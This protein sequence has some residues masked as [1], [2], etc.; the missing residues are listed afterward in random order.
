MDRRHWIAFVAIAALA[1]TET[2]AELFRCT[3][4]DG[5]T[6][7]TDQKGACPDAEP[8]E[9]SGVVHSAPPSPTRPPA[10][11]Q[12]DRHL[13]ERAEEEAA[14]VWK[15]KKRDAEAR[16][17]R[18]QQR[19]ERMKPYV[20]HC[21][22]GGYVTTRDE[23]GIEDAVNCSVLRREFAALDDQEAEARNYLENVLPEECRK[24]GCLPGWLR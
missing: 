8:F 22:R 13:S 10:A 16:I 12:R 24:A 3:G 1:A 11:V 15:Q 18:I 20:G 21:N 23:A 2:A 14:K 9:P 5:K 6:I 7:F 4:P 19:R 17:E